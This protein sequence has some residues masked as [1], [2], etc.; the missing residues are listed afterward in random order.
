MKTNRR[1]FSF[2]EL[3]VVMIVLGVLTR[4]GIPRYKDM[5]QRA[6]AASIIGDVRAL[7]SAA[8]T[9]YADKNTWPAEVGAGV[10]PSELLTYLP[11]QFAFIKP[12]YQLDWDVWSAS[13]SQESMVGVTIT[14][15]DPVITA[16]I[17]R[18]SQSGYI[19]MYSGST[20]TLL[21]SGSAS[22]AGTP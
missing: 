15:D 3:L 2:I 11:Q 4:L 5:K 8:Y 18:L 1:G 10:L 20:I 12:G 21:I 13:A 19:P 6:I 17:Y 14:A 22:Q 7:R 9:Y 16:M